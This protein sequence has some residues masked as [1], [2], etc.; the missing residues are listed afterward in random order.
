MKDKDFTRGLA[1][2]WEGV[3]ELREIQREIERYRIE[4][5]ELHRKVNQGY[6]VQ[7]IPLFA[8]ERPPEPP[9][10]PVP[11]VTIDDDQ[12]APVPIGTCV[13]HGSPWDEVQPGG[14]VYRVVDSRITQDDFRTNQDERVY[15]RCYKL[16]CVLHVGSP[17][18]HGEMRWVTR[19]SI[20]PVNIADLGRIR[21]EIDTLM[22]EIVSN[23][24][25]VDD[26]QDR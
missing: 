22:R 13:W 19:K 9:T 4:N 21:Q 7:G 26:D 17:R 18:T 2:E 20:V 16:R 8:K 15:A 25:G 6:D 12:E 3:R 11:T 10:P 24:S 1:D 14:C 23:M 5:E